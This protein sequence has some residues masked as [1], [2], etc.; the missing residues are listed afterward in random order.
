MNTVK[1]VASQIIYCVISKLTM[2]DKRLYPR[3]ELEL[4][5]TLRHNGRLLPATM[6]N[7]SCGGMCIRTEGYH[8]T[9]STPVEVVFDL[10][11]KT[12]DVSV[13]AQI[14]HIFDENAG[15]SKAGLQFINIFSTSHKAI[16]E[17]LRK[18]LN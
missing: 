1:E 13:R 4:P 8:L 18:N 7:L 15:E 2:N 14:M 11:E 10:D 5:V 17:Y 3:I 9:N 6:L 16:Q 12:R